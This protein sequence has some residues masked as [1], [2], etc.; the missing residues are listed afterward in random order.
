MGFS[1]KK[2]FS[3]LAVLSM[4][5]C[6]QINYKGEVFEETSKVDVFKDRAAVSQPYKIMGTASASGPYEKYSQEDII[7]DLKE[8]AMASGADGIVIT[9]YEVLPTDQVRKDQFLSG[10][11][12]RAVNDDSTD[13]LSRISQ[14]FDNNYGQYGQKSNTSEVRT[15]KRFIKADFIK[16]CK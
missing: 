10:S 9:S 6:V 12:G 5:A 16:Y 15:Y 3:A 11:S 8:K 13:D 2:T 14:D 4:T 1:L 7:K